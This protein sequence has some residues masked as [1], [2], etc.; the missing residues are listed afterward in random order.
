MWPSIKHWLDWATRAMHELWPT[1][2]IGP[3]PQAMHF[4][5]EKAGLLLDNQAIPWNAETVIVEALVRQPPG[6]S[7]QKKDFTLSIKGGQVHQV[8]GLQAEPQGQR[9]RLTFRIPVPPR[10]T[11]AEVLWKTRSLGQMT[12]P[13]LTRDEFCRQLNLQMPTLSAQLGEQ[14]VACQTFVST[15]CQGLIVTA[16]LSAPTSLAPILDLGLRVELRAEGR[17]QTHDVPV[18]LTSSQLRGRQAVITVVPPRPRRI[19]A[20]QATWLLGNQ[21][22]ASQRICAISRPHFLRSLR[23]S[24]ARFICQDARGQV[25]LLRQ[26]PSPEQAC[27]VGPCFLVCSRELGMAGLCDLQVRAQVHGS[28]QAPLLFEQEMLITDGPT[29]FAPGTLSIDDLTEVTG[30]ELR[31]KNRVLGILPM[32]PAPTAS[33]SAEGGFKPPPE[34]IWS[35]AADEQLNEK[36][37]RLLGN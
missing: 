10:S 23:I 33:F 20:W 17:G 4:R 31:A 5:C 1:P 11:T 14:A 3:Q 6:T 13:I 28:V 25:R 2:R 26:L 12:L 16:I 37:G 36:L 8:D 15:Q 7:R 32:T 29:P 19:G 21:P 30:F 34:F 22:L 35:P 24:E 27:R 18:Q 9:T